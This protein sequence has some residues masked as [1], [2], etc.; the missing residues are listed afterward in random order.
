MKIKE[1]IAISE[2]G[3]IFDSNTGDSYNLNPIGQTILKQ[4]KEKKTAVEIQNQLLEEFDVEPDVLDSA[5]YDFI[6]MLRQ[7]NL[8]ENE[9]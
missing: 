1:N 2:S 3:F 9:N 4:M 5:F 7:F 6:G 8:I